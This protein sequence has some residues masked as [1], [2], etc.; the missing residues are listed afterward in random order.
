MPPITLPMPPPQ[1]PPQMPSPSP[2][3]TSAWPLQQSPQQPQAGSEGGAG[4]GS[5][6]E[7]GGDGG[8]GDGGGGEGKGGDSGG[9]E[10]GGGGGTEELHGT[11]EPH[12]AEELTPRN[13]SIYSPEQTAAVTS[14]FTSIVVT[15]VAGT[16]V[17]SVAGAASAGTGAGSSSGGLGPLILGLQRLSL[18][19]GIATPQSDLSLTVANSME[20]ASGDLGLF[21]SWSDYVGWA[22][23]ACDNDGGDFDKGGAQKL[24]NSTEICAYFRGTVVSPCYIHL[25]QSDMLL[26]ESIGRP[27]I[28]L[29]GTPQAL[30]GHWLHYYHDEASMRTITTSSFW[31]VVTRDGRAVADPCGS[32][33]IPMREVGQQPSQPQ[34]ANMTTARRSLQASVVDDDGGTHAQD[35]CSGPLPIVLTKLLGSIG[36]L[37]IAVGVVVALYVLVYLMWTHRVNRN[38]YLQR[39]ALEELHR[40]SPS[41][42]S[43]RL[44]RQATATLRRHETLDSLKIVDGEEQ[45]KIAFVPL[46]SAL[47][48]PGLLLI[49]F[50]IFVTNLVKL[51]VTLLANG[52]VAACHKVG[53]ALVLLAC[54]AWCLSICAL[55]FFIDARYRKQCWKPSKDLDN[56]A[57][58]ADPLFRL[59]SRVRVRICQYVGWPGTSVVYDRSRGKWAKPPT[60][61]AEPERTERLLASPMAIIRGNAADVLDSYAFAIMP[62]ATGGRFITQIFDHLTATI[63]VTPPARWPSFPA[64]PILSV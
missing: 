36:T 29:S 35:P 64:L 19:T 37:S 48:F 42:H 57:A 13:R 4:D 26:F 32:G 2:L 44:K 43:S 41:G 11:E 58:V 52:E 21:S 14:V 16:V 22:S 40:H 60:E 46:P 31:H 61:L 20:W 45:V 56:P 10:G 23:F 3:T 24:T 5:G 50:K 28:R 18:T 1:M 27:A 53:G 59:I 30:F 63:T 12:G 39:R 33:G 15:A 38:F 47:V 54:G 34:D 25:S 49:V 17:A 6:G 55:L 62:R 51:S 7:G 9:A 8:G